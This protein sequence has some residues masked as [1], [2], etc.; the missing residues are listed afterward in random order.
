MYVQ[1][2]VS[3]GTVCPPGIWLLFAPGLRIQSGLLRRELARHPQE[4]ATSLDAYAFISPRLQRPLL[5]VLPP[6]VFAV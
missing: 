2:P 5:S 1:T 6:C 4:A 3:K